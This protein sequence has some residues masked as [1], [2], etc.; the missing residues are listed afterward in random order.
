MPAARMT[1]DQLQETI[2]LV[3]K[4]GTVTKAAAATGQPRT[5]LQA[6]YNQARLGVPARDETSQ[7]TPQQPPNLTARERAPRAPVID[8]DP[9][10]RIFVI[11]DTQVRP[12][13]PTDNIDWIA[14]AIVDY[15]PDEVV[16]LGDHWDFPSLNGHEKPGSAPLEGARFSDDV[17]SGNMAFA[18]LSKPM[19][20]EIARQKRTKSNQLWLPRRRFCKG[21][22]EARPDRIASADPK[23]MGHVGSHHCNTLDWEVSEFLEIIYIN[24]I[25]FSH[26]FQNTHSSYPIGGEVSSRLTKIGSSFV[27]GHEQGKR[28]GNKLTACGRT[29]YG[30][31]SGSAYLH[32]EPFRGRQGQRHWRGAHL[33]NEAH[34][35]EWDACE[36]SLGYLCKKYE[37]MPLP[38]FMSKKYPDGD[39]EHLR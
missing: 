1:A 31:V 20:D 8:T 24:K 38:E 10:K 35:G 3:S 18:R 23:W 7:N 39:W 13:I 14:Q 12:G 19:D 26:Y 2:D 29:M 16:H 36:L 15:A 28:T 21:N 6:R 33:L 11:P 32:I 30:L 5:T 17:I 34:D 9:P 4:H 22:H 37:G 27:C 25:A